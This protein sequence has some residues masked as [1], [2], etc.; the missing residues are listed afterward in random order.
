MSDPSLLLGDADRAVVNKLLS[1]IAHDVPRP[2]RLMEVCGTHTMALF[3]TGLRQPLARLGIELVSGPGCP[4]CVTS[5]ADLDFAL[6]LAQL[7]QVTLCTFGDM[8][9]VPGSTASLDEIKAAGADVRVVYSPTDA[10]ELA[11]ANSARCIIFLGI[12]FETTAPGVAFSITYAKQLGITNYYVFPVHKL[13][14]PALELLAQDPQLLLDGFICPGHVSVVIG[15]QAYARVAERWRKPCVIT[16]F[17]ALDLLQ[18]IQAAVRQIEHGMSDVENTYR[19][20]VR[21]AGNPAAQALIAEVFMPCAAEWRGLGM[22]A[23][24]GLALR[25][26]YARFDARLLLPGYSPPPANPALSRC[27]C[28]DVLKGLIRP[29]ACGCFGA[30]CTPERPLGACMVS[31]EGACR[32]YY[33]YREPGGSP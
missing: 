5:A 15:A 23:G 30:A 1:Q 7:P 22:L 13:I 8:L 10:V 33:R 12:G 31:Q 21:D 11:Q 14:P 2:L 24:S 16:G 17:G 3:E 9:R 27:R 28:G 32:A 6:A 29:D 19:R 18:G 20:A 25:E 4:V 26:A